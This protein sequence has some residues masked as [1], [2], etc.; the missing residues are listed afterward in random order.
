MQRRRRT[1][2]KHTRTGGGLATR[3]MLFFSAVIILAGIANRFTGGDEL[4]ATVLATP[5]PTPLTATFDETVEIRE[6]TLPAEVWYCLQSGIFS[7]EAA[8]REKSLAYSDR[9][10]PG[11]VSP[12]GGKFRVLLSA[13]ASREDAQRVK[14]KLAGQQ[15]VETYIYEMVRPALHLQLTGMRGQLDVLDAAAALLPELAQSWR[16]TALTLDQGQTSLTEVQEL[17]A[18]QQEQCLVMLNVLQE[19]FLP[20]MPTLAQQ[21]QALLTQA[22]ASARRVQDAV[23]QGR[24]AASAQLKMEALAGHQALKDV[25]E[26]ILAE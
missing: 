19:R 13:Y 10:A 9:G 15:S 1:E 26:T 23:G 16:E 3:V 17:A 4:T 21:L 14:E 7:S 11:F 2:R 18:E 6:I 24:T 20:P 12:E 22:E 25:W 8:A 5:S